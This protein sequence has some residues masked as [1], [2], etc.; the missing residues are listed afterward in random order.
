MENSITWLLLADASKAKIYSLHKARLFH[1]PNNTDNLK[2][3]H[4][5]AHNESRMKN[6]DLVADRL[7][8]FGSGTFV[9]A[10]SPKV[11]EAELFANQLIAALQVGRNQYRDLI[12]VASP[13]FMGLL[14]K[15]MPTEIK[16]LI[17]QKIEK[18]YT[19]Q[20]GHEL[21]ESLLIHL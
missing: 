2:L 8:E 12:I 3:L 18:D 16:K 9:E 15:H 1:Q 11:H 10:S 4:E 7:G 5:Y 14:N 21:L 6:H 19:Q 13:M 20:N 17:T